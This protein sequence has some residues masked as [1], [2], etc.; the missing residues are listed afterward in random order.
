MKLNCI[1]QLLVY[2]G[3]VNLQS[4]SIRTHYGTQAVLVTSKETGLEVNA[5]KTMYEFMFCEQ[6]ARHNHNI[7]IGNK[8][9]ENVAKFRYLQATLTYE[10]CIHKNIKSGLKSGS[11]R[12]VLVQNLVSSSLLS[13]NMIKMCITILFFHVGVKLRFSH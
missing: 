3:D 13:K 8:S 2:N 6:K 4:K 10:N 7:K 5:E 11:A 9:T 1:H 12:Y